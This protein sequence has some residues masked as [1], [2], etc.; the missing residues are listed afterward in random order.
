VFGRLKRS[1]I[2]PG[3]RTWKKCTFVRDSR[4]GTCG[5]EAFEDAGVPKEC[6]RVDGRLLAS[7]REKWPERAALSSFVMSASV[8]LF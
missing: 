1:T 2:S 5:Y 4:I 3:H 7:R 6:R 8:L